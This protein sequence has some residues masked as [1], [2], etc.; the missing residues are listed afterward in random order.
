MILEERSEICANAGSA[1]WTTTWPPDAAVA[2][3]STTNKEKG[4][5]SEG[6]APPTPRQSR[7]GFSPRNQQ[8]LGGEGWFGG[9]GEGVDGS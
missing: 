6:A 1:A 5:V 7:F 9:V 4:P 8:D 2:V 3:Y